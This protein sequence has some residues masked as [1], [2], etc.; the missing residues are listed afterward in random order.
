LRPSLERIIDL[1]EGPDSPFQ[2]LCQ[3]EFQTTDISSIGK[4]LGK[5]HV[6][7]EAA[8]KARVFAITD[9][10]TQSV[11]RPL[12]QFLFSL[13]RTNPCDGTFNQGA[14]LE[15][16][17]ALK[18]EG[19]L[20]GHRFH[21]YDLSAATDRLPI[22]LQRDI[23]GYYVGSEIADLWAKLLTDRDWYLDNQPYRYAVG[24][25]MGALSS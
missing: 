15:R 24:Q 25:P 14:P 16:L 13:L 9:A 17:L 23:L 11:L 21:S 8:G 4:V 22:N 2:K 12:H 10:I 20:D 6:K 5:L 7:E 3:E 18:R 19:A 1:L